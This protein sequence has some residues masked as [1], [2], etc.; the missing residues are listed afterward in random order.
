MFS[1][2]NVTS[3]IKAMYYITLRGVASY[4]IVFSYNFGGNNLILGVSRPVKATPLV[5]LWTKKTMKSE[6]YVIGYRLEVRFSLQS[7]GGVVIR[8][9]H[10]I[11]NSCVMDKGS[12][13]IN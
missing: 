3:H 12:I 4:C 5:L 2:I 1:R 10:G 9:S 6:I 11:D 8:P 13:R 7:S